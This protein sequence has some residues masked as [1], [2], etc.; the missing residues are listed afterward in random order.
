M[1]QAKILIDEL[2]TLMGKTD[3][4]SEQRRR[5]I[6]LWFRDNSNPE[7][8]ALFENFINKGV[9]QVADALESIRL[10]ID[11]EEYKLLPLSY[12]AT[13]YFGKSRAWLYQRINGTKVRGHQYTLSKEQRA[14]FNAA[15][16][17][18]SRRIGSICI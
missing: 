17:D 7:N 10:K 8:D 15:V 16:Q 6:S 11:A 1:E 9:G 4:Q 3:E 18:I 2:G 14:T 5:E 12:I 13:H